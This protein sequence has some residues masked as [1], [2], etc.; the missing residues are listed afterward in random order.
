MKTFKRHLA[1]LAL[2]AGLPLAAVAQTYPD[3]TIKMILPFPPGSA[4]DGIARFVADDLRKSLGQSIVVENQAG[5]DGIVAAQN[6]K[7][8]APDG[9]T[10]FLTTN[11][12][13]GVNPSVYNQLP[14]DPEKDF[15]PI[16]GIM[17]IPQ[18]MVVRSDFPADDVAGFVKV[19][20]ERAATKGLSFG[21]GNTSSL[22][23]AELLKAAAQIDMVAIPYRGTPQALQ[24]L[25]GGQIDV[26]FAD[27]FAAAGFVNAGQ[28]KA[29]AVTDTTRVPL[30][31]KVPT[32]TEAGFKDVHLVSWAATFV[33]AKTDPAIIERLNKEINLTLAKPATKEYLLRMGATPLPMTPGE[34]RSFVH[35]EIARWA[36]LVEIARIPKK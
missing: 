4:T 17:R 25:V 27:P 9:Y 16:G 12:S 6:V 26:F 29:L 30:L 32:M 31:P 15:E 35:A 34:L 23:A 8:A 24:D 7:R 21:T 18:L 20:K 2:V 33:P 22:V 3:H 36:G 19:A 14:Y 10:I 5:A 11:S 1:T 13:H 28:I